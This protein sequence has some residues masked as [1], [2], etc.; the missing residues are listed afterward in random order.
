MPA[1]SV[2]VPMYNVE[3]YVSQCLQSLQRQTFEDFEA[4][5]IDD[6][7]TDGT[8]SVAQETVVGDSRFAFV[9]Q[10]NAGQSAARNVGIDRASGAYVLF[11]DSDDYYVEGALAYLYERAERE[12]LDDLFFSARTEYEDAQSRRLYR[13]E[14][15]ER[16]DIPGVMTGREIFA[17]FAEEDSF[18]VSPAMQF[19]RRE[20]LEASRIRFYEGIVHE[21]NLFTCMM[22]A[23][24]RRTG[25]SN[26]QFYVRRVRAESTMTAKRE[27]RHVYG[28]FKSAYELEKWIR[29]N[30]ETCSRE[31]V[32]V[33]LHHISFC[34]DLSAFDAL[35]IDEDALEA[36]A[37]SLPHDEEI[38]FRLH[39]IE[40][41]RE[42]GGVRKEYLDSTTY[43]IGHAIMTVPCWLKERFGR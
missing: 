3:Q 22:L 20:F 30:S 7:S 14:Y 32:K 41:A 18:C 12:R 5:C 27:V 33:F 28:H 19:I 37:C 11:L 26:K 1:I 6:G 43:K 2:V 39:V 29:A 9:S 25:F 10:E 36:R 23:Y 17:R 21:D 13:D 4:I 31:F 15:E 42:M 16:A 8:L 38:S 24:A 40:H 35:S 34:Y